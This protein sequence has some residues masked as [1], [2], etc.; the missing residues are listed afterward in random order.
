M[1]RSGKFS[2]LYTYLLLSKVGDVTL[3]SKVG[4]TFLSLADEFVTSL[5]DIR[6]IGLIGLV[7]SLMTL[8]F[9]RTAALTYCV[10]NLPVPVTFAD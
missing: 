10:D 6:L 1:T 2:F 4:V 9:L 3:L 5:V 8:L 7:T